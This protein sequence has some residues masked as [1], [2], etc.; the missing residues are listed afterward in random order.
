MESRETKKH[1]VNVAELRMFDPI[2]VILAVSYNAK[3][4]K[5]NNGH[6]KIDPPQQSEALIRMLISPSYQI[7]TITT[8]HITAIT[9]NSELIHALDKNTTV[10]DIIQE[11][12]TQW[13]KL[14]AIETSNTQGNTEKLALILARNRFLSQPDNQEHLL[15]FQNLMNPENAERFTA[16]LEHQYPQEFNERYK[17]IFPATLLPLD[18]ALQPYKK[19]QKAFHDA[20]LNPNFH[21]QFLT[22]VYE[23]I[24]QWLE[25]DPRS[26]VA[27][28]TLILKHQPSL[29]P[30]KLD[31]DSARLELNIISLLIKHS[32]TD[33]LANIIATTNQFID[34]ITSSE[35]I[36]NEIKL[37]LTGGNESLFYMVLKAPIASNT[38]LDNTSDKNSS[39]KEHKEGNAYQEEYPWQN[40]IEKLIQLFTTLKELTYQGSCA[41]SKYFNHPLSS[42]IGYASQSTD[43]KILDLTLRLY[44]KAQQL[45]ES[46]RFSQ[47]AA[48]WSNLYDICDNAHF[49]LEQ[50][51]LTI[52][53][54]LHQQ[55]PT[56]EECLFLTNLNEKKQSI[57]SL[58]ITLHIDCIGD[59]IEFI[60]ELPSYAKI[61]DVLRNDTSLIT[62]ACVASKQDK[63]ASLTATV[64]L[65]S[66]AM[67]EINIDSRSKKTS[68]T[69]EM[70]GFLCNTGIKGSEK[71]YLLSLLLIGKT[72]E[73]T[74]YILCDTNFLTAMLGAD[75]DSCIA[76]FIQN[77]ILSYCG[78]E[79]FADLWQSY[80]QASLQSLR[81]ELT[82]YKTD[83]S[84]D[85]GMPKALQILPPEEWVEPFFN[86][87][88]KSSRN[89]PLPSGNLQPETLHN[90]QGIS[91]PEL[92]LPYLLLAHGMY[93]KTRGKQL[94]YANRAGIF[95]ERV[96]ELL[97]KKAVPDD[98]TRL[99]DSTFSRLNQQ[100]P[101][102][103]LPTE[104]AK[105]TA[106]TFLYEFCQKE[107]RNPDNVRGEKFQELV[108]KPLKKK[109]KLLFNAAEVTLMA[110]AST[111]TFD[112]AASPQAASRTST[113]KIYTPDGNDGGNPHTQYK[114]GTPNARP[115]SIELHQ[116]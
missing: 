91:F 27:A 5:E 95:M 28:L 14:Q 104:E 24:E 8:T 15:A 75:S 67:I 19:L 56:A 32:N 21:G 20:Q 23:N 64:A 54:A 29:L 65:Y 115:S 59:L 35:E 40:T 18:P 12:P 36:K 112:D 33:E 10:T 43:S 70:K 90:A 69:S 102:Q 44:T 61:C 80:T 111:H 77:H 34:E 99:L 45:D 100:L 74:R 110:T 50:K 48:T 3:K 52:Q 98:Q 88:S 78:E 53:M 22:A 81:A 82:S 85:Y 17:A 30:V 72:L 87:S 76:D 38:N 96:D 60:Q 7:T 106:F 11:V 25:N 68:F 2:E 37:K 84:V 57:L 58:L 89:E 41:L 6:F 92:T 73:Q 63:G 1:S 83:D 108:L 49:T 79:G 114:I 51:R 13:L 109:L 66:A 103:A 105:K 16:A 101:T 26:I 71:L 113:A 93:F 39:A 62:Q 42:L 31:K 94:A 4:E 47:C 9:S 97:G 107:R 116:L 55:E 86:L 46:F